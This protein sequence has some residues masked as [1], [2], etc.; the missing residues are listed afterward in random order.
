MSITKVG[1]RP[2]PLYRQRADDKI[3]GCFG[4][5]SGVGDAADAI[6]RRPIHHGWRNPAEDSELRSVQLPQSCSRP[7]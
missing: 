3:H 7:A 6:H 1:S 2:P 4:G 5:V